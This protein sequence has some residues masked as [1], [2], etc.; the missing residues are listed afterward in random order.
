MRTSFFYTILLLSSLLTST[1]ITA[2]A[3]LSFQGILK[4]A[5]GVA[6]EDGTYPITFSLYNDSIG[7]TRLWS[8]TQSNVEVSSGIYSVLLGSKQELNVAFDQIYY[9]GIKVG[10]YEMTPRL[11][12]TTA[13]YALS[14]VGQSNLFPSAGTVKADDLTIAGKLSVGDSTLSPTHTIFVSGGIIA[15][16]GAPGTDGTSNKGYA[17]DGDEDSGLFSTEEGTVSIF[18]NNT[19]QLKV[20]SD[21]VEITGDLALQDGSDIH[22]GANGGIQYT[23]K[24]DVV[25]PDWRLWKVDKFTNLNTQ[26]WQEYSSEKSTSGE[27]LSPFQPKSPFTKTYAI[28]PSSNVYCL[29]KMYDLSEAFESFQQNEIKEI[30]VVFTYHIMGT[31]DIYQKKYALAGF[32]ENLSQDITVAWTHAGAGW[33]DSWIYDLYDSPYNSKGN[34][35]QGEMIARFTLETAN[36]IWVVFTTRNLSGAENF[37][38]SDVEIWVR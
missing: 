23:G 36:S 2:Q 38:I 9:L 5:N 1:S 33:G 8:E 37:A 16:P 22:L 4:K 26:E 6:V 19:E 34:Y 14:L 15:Q 11:Q 25:Y 10:S 13:P 30:K 31:W 27:S 20:T 21:G 29:K 35:I 17:F 3:T 7:G 12:L 24:D 28:R 32:Q 18:A